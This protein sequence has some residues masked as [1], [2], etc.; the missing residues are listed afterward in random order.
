MGKLWIAQMGFSLILTLAGSAT[1][2][3]DCTPGDVDSD[4]DVD[5]ADFQLF[6]RCFAGSD[7]G[8]PSGCGDLDLDNDSDIDL[9]DFEAFQSVVTGPV[10]RFDY[11]ASPRPDV[12]A[13]QLALENGTTL[14]A[15]D[16][17]YD[18]IRRDL[19]AIADLE[20]NVANV[21]HSGA[22]APTQMI[23]KV[24]DG[25]PT[26]DFD[27]LN[28]FYQV[29]EVQFLFQSGGG[30]WYVVHF[31]GRLNIPLLGNEYT[32]LS[33]VQFADP[34]SLIGGNDIIDIV[35]SGGPDGTWTYDI[36]D[37]WLDCFDGCDCHAFWLFDVTGDGE[38][39]NTFMQCAGASW[40]EFP[41][42]CD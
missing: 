7:G 26:C 17:M 24:T 39:I 14:L 37:G 38:A 27:A 20:P 40:C 3:S 16:A 9:S 10:A 32:A 30:T 8:V 1:L 4:A 35:T 22:W 11:G 12:E 41:D 18:R 13:E 42:F 36:D 15:T 33:E 31:P 34:D 5:F 28:A 19:T 29:T 25:V 23:V 21:S 2:A 6:Q